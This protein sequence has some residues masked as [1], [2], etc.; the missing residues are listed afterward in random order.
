MDTPLWCWL[1]TSALILVLLSVDFVVHRGERAPTL[2][3]AVIA[4]SAWIS[5]SVV[6]GVVMG[7][8]G[9]WESAGEYFGGY[10][11]EKSLSIDNIF[12]FAIIFRA[13]AVPVAY[14]RRVLFYGVFGALF[15]RGA[16][17]AVGASLV[18]HFGWVFYI[19]GVVLIFSGVRMLRGSELLVPDRNVAIRL[20]R[21]VL[22]VAPSYVGQTFV[23]RV[24]GT[25]IA[26]PLLIALLAIEVTDLVFAMDSIPAAFGIT[27]N[28]F[29]IFTANAFAVLGLR[30]LYFVL[31]GAM[32]R[33]TYVNVGLALL[34][35]FIGCKML[36]TPFLTIP[37]VV[38]VAVIA[39][40]MSASIA[41][42]FWHER[43]VALVP[44]E[45][46]E[47]TGAGQ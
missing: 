6:F 26:T 8:I 27:K 47:L 10:L 19:L 28:V 38:S 11:T 5:V 15:F 25:L 21:R 12:V 29:V 18:E 7:V 20:L 30:S 9:S 45:Q 35:V 17:I 31:V 3:K 40:I 4:S 44:C 41:V 1:A 23:S 37:I 24:N 22:P 14:Q 34:L 2:R 42:S 36:L 13:F 46:R 16:L 32:D 39:V 43:H 33:F